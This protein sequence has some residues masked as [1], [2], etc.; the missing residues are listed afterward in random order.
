[1]VVQNSAIPDFQ[2]YNRQRVKKSER[3]FR[4]R[5]YCESYQIS[6]QAVIS[7]RT[8]INFRSNF[9]VERV[10]KH[11][12]SFQPLLGQRKFENLK[13]EDRTDVTEM[14]D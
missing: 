4:T 9:V 5:G 7:L 6:S 14:K 3:E 2:R 1:L 11:D 8:C 10:E 13:R 12:W